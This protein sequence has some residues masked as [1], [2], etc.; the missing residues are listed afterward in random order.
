MTNAPMTGPATVPMPPTTTMTSAVTTQSRP[1]IEVGSMDTWLRAMAPPSRPVMTALSTSACRLTERVDTPSAAA[2]PSSSRTAINRRPKVERSTTDVTTHATT[3]SAAITWKAT[4]RSG[5]AASG[6][7]SPRLSPVHVQV[8]IQAWAI[9]ATAE[10][11]M[12]K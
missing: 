9:S 3:A 4:A 12:V 11:P 2:A 7:V 5:T 6:M 1:N 8:T 10:E